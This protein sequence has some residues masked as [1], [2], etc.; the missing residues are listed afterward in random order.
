MAADELVDQVDEHDGSGDPQGDAQ[1]SCLKDHGRPEGAE[2]DV[3]QIHRRGA[4]IDSTLP[5]KALADALGYETRQGRACRT[6]RGIY[7]LV[8]SPTPARGRHGNPTELAS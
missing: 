6:G 3:P 1:R 2:H 8:P 7:Q 4:V 5:V